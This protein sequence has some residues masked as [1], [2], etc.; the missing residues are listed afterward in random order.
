LEITHLE[1]WR[2]L[3]H[4]LGEPVI[5]ADGPVDVAYPAEQFL[6]F[7]AFSDRWHDWLDVVLCKKGL[8]ALQVRLQIGS[9]DKDSPLH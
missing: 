5:A 1:P 6:G 2:R 3:E 8:E 9:G 4:L 7:E